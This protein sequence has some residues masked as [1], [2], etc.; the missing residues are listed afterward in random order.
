MTVHMIFFNLHFS[1]VTGGSVGI[2]EHKCNQIDLWA[3]EE[4]KIKKGR[5]GCSITILTNR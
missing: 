2:R 1:E 3:M 4:C 5:K